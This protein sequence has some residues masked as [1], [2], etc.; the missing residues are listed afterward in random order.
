[1]MSAW[2]MQDYG[3]CDGARAALEF[4]L[5]RQ[6]DDGKIMHELTQSAA[7]LDWSKYPHGYYHADTTPLFLY[8]AARYL[9]QT[10]DRAFLEQYWPQLEKCYRFCLT[11]ADPDGLLSN[12]KGGAAAVETGALSGKVR[13]DVYLQG[14]WLGGLDGFAQMAG[15]MNKAPLRAEA[16]ERLAK[17]REA[18]KSWFVPARGIFAFAELND[19]SRYEAN[20]GWQG[21]LAAFGGVDSTM[22]RRTAA[23]LAG[24]A[25][26]TPWGTRLFATG[27][28]SYNPLGYN[29][30]SVWPFVTA[31][32]AMAMFLHGQEASGYRYLHGMA[33]ATGLSGAGFISEYFSGDRFAEGPRAVPH[34]LFSSAALIHPLVGGMLGLEPDA[35]QNTLRIDARIPCQA[36]PVRFEN[37]RVG[38]S[39]VSAEIFPSKPSSVMQF[40]NTGPI[41]LIIRGDS[42]CIDVPPLKPLTPGQRAE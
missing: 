7:L 4:L 23:S 8:S 41:L 25:L 30:G 11:M 29:D 17:G 32:A 39:V 31:Q 3:D 13:R 38:Q 42:P 12:E 2:A 27:S 22:A 26:A 1:M 16:V 33:Q 34:Q 5:A 19:G 15:W 21:F 35:M 37:Y 14:V 24:P 28:P 18:I 40:R 9:R 20:S 6:R 10:G 36:G